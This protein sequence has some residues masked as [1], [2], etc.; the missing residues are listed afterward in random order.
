M[1]DHRRSSAADRARHGSVQ[2]QHRSSTPP[3]TRHDAATSPVQSFPRATAAGSRRN[4]LQSTSC[5]FGVR[6]FRFIGNSSPSTSIR[7]RSPAFNQ[8]LRVVCGGR[9]TSS[10]RHRPR[11]RGRRPMTVPDR[12][13]D[14]VASPHSSRD[15]AAPGSRSEGRTV[16]DSADGIPTFRPS[17]AAHPGNA[18]HAGAEAVARWR[19]RSCVGQ[20]SRSLRHDEHRIIRRPLSSVVSPQQMCSRGDAAPVQLGR[21]PE[22]EQ[23]RLALEGQKEQGR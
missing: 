4:S 21:D 20:M 11:V 5:C 16:V 12:E 10:H 22:L 1:P 18:G 8:R 2:R 6:R 15:G 7:M 9:P 3:D 23:P 17:S 19:R 13:V 14:Q